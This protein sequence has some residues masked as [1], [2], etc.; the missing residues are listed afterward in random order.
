[1][2]YHQA[3]NAMSIGQM[4][5][6]HGGERG[7]IISVSQKRAARVDINGTPYSFG[8]MF[9]SCTLLGFGKSGGTVYEARIEDVMTEDEYQKSKEEHHETKS[10][11]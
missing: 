2:T 7:I 8:D 5:R 1:M 9:H 6:G 4:C 3:L 10:T 11:V